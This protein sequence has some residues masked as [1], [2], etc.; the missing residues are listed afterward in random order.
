MPQFQHDQAGIQRALYDHHA[1]QKDAYNQNL[2]QQEAKPLIVVQEDY[3]EQKH[4]RTVSRKKYYVPTALRT[5][6]LV[7]FCITVL[8]VFAAL[9]A[10]SVVYLM[11]HGFDAHATDSSHAKR[12]AYTQTSSPSCPPGATC[13]PAPGS[14]TDPTDSNG[15]TA[16]GPGSFTSPAAIYFFGAYAPTLLAILLGIWWNCVFAR[17]KEMEPY[18]QLAK[19][20][21]AR[22]NDSL[23][24]SYSS[25]LLP[26]VLSKSLR[27]KHWLTFIGAGNMTLITV[28][29]LF[30]AE[31]IKLIGVGD[32]CGVV[33]DAGE[34]SNEDCKMQLS[35]K[36]AL[37]FILGG[38][39]LAVLFGTALLV[40]RLRRHSS[41]LVSEATS[42]AG[43][44]ALST[45]ALAQSLPQ[46]L[47]HPGRMF[48]LVRSEA[49]GTTS[50]VEITPAVQEP[51]LQPFQF[52]PTSPT[53][54][55]RESHREM[56]SIFLAVFLIYQVAILSLI[57]YYGFISKPGTNDPLEDFMNSESFGVRLFMTFLGLGTKFYW[58]WIEKYVRRISPY[59][60]LAAP[61][62]ATPQKSVL[63]TTHSHPITALFSRSTWRHTLLGPVTL[64]AVLSEILVVTLN[65]V[66]FTDTTAY[67]AFQ[68]SVYF[69]ILILAMM[70]L[71]MPGVIVWAMG[72]K[73]KY[74][75]ADA[76]E[77]IADVI[78][79][80]GH[81]EFWR[82]LGGLNE[83]DRTKIVDSW[84]IKFATRQVQ[85]R[86]QIVTLK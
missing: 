44:A 21:G 10:V 39:M 9:Q 13:A 65:T 52:P 35:V 32:G 86:W 62:G 84:H 74:N 81:T 2:S 17:L 63:M 66:P 22:P 68:V 60:A 51:M 33:V 4:K 16:P 40:V 12:G 54:P 75:V 58:G 79:M 45:S 18:Y 26:V 57:V 46:S 37:G 15:A 82:G 19:K 49:G 1:I 69:C 11:A 85:G 5:G 28:I 55:K 25:D 73:R 8:L 48:A 43:V 38:I 29:T 83:K 72:I 53:A 23:F 31:T 77:C 78:W 27:A 80:A 3:V 70:I 50:I 47:Q 64:M 71:T 76:P 56:R 36:P 41:G 14:W 30:A 24:L 20:A 59:V 7:A 67:T 6:C 61:E 42:I 34:G